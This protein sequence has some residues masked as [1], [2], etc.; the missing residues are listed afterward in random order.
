MNAR[1]TQRA[2]LVRRSGSQYAARARRMLA[3]NAQN[4]ARG[5]VG[6]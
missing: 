2:R 5:G 3:H 1:S 4:P 6:I